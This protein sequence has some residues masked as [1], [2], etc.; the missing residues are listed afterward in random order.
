MASARTR[1]W[2]ALLISAALL[3]AAFLLG[4]WAGYEHITPQSLQHDA[5]ARAVFFR[6]RVPR[7]LLAAITGASLSIVGAALQ[8][9]FRNPLA[10][11]FTLGVSGGGALG[12]S[13]AIALGWGASTLGVPVVF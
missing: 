4:I 8:A 5:I 1:L 10:E 2:R 11:P 7:V 6:V 12:A 3:V 9:H 13:V